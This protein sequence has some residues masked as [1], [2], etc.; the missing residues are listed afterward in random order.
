MK[1]APFIGP[2]VG[3]TDVTLKAQEAA[4]THTPSQT[5]EA[6]PASASGVASME[7]T[8]EAPES[9][10]GPA[11]SGVKPESAANG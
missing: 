6:Q 5:T 11:V 10:P 9:P 4:C 8:S 1:F 3:L 7:T 2:P